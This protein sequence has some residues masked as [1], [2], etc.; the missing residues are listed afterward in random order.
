VKP[1]PW[2]RVW[3]VLAV[4]VIIF[5]GWKLFIAPRALKGADA[6][7]VPQIA[8]QRLD[9]TTLHPA[10]S[11][12]K[13]EF[14]DFFASWCE[15]CRL[16]LPMVER[17][18]KHHP[19]IAL[20]PIDVGE[21]RVVAETFAERMHLGNIAFDPASLSQGYFQLDGFPTIVVVDPEGKIRA[22]WSGF[23]PA[24][25]LAMSNAEQELRAT[26]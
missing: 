1:F 26:P 20:V 12:G 7:P 6:H 18:A 9:G 10:Q 17:Y 3:D 2:A 22:T 16:S 4:A 23:N 13:V 19:E 8:Y 11:G 24:I 21:P 25:D 5:V 15:P 14:L